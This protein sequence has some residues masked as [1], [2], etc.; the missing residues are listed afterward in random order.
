MLRLVAKRIAIGVSILEAEDAVVAIDNA[1]SSS[2]VARQ[3]RVPDWMDIAGAHRLAYLKMRRAALQRAG[4]AARNRLQSLRGRERRSR[5]GRTPRTL[6]V[7]DFLAR[8]QTA[9]GQALNERRE[10]LFVVAHPQ[11]VD[12]RDAFQIV[13]REAQFAG[14]PHGKGQ[15]QHPPLPPRVKHGL[16]LF[17]FDR[18]QAVHAAHVVNAV[19]AWPPDLGGATLATPIIESLVTSAASSA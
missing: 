2:R 1:L 3:S 16:V 15:R 18:A 11:I 14:G 4:P 5:L 7:L 13:A 9:Q 19:H 10:P 8:H 6:P 17:H 12:R